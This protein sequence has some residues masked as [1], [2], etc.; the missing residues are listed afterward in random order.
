MRSEQYE[1]LCRLYLSQQLG[2]PL[3]SITSKRLPS[4]KRPGNFEYTH[5]IDFYWETK[6]EF[7]VYKN[8]ADA[9]WRTMKKVDQGEVL[10][11][12]QVR[13][14]VGA[15][16]ALMITN[17]GFTSGAILAAKDEGIG[18]H[19]VKPQL[20]TDQLPKRHRVAIRK[21]LLQLIA[22]GTTRLFISTVVY[23]GISLGG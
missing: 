1:E 16:K 15:H 6:G 8:I 7:I 14:K 11:L 12:Q 20:D 3:E 21:R 2:I 4:P 18:L 23:A 19:I 5:Q 22:E 10:L 9:K 13:Q 17:I